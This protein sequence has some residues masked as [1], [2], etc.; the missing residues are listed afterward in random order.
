MDKTF[1]FMVDFTLPFYLDQQFIDLIPQQRAKINKYFLNGQ[2]ANY[3]LSLEKSKL[4]AI[5]NADTRDEVLDIIQDFPL[6]KFMKYRIYP[7]TFNQT[8]NSKVPSFSLN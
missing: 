6:T 1:Q 2:L 3:V 7:L 4:W 8:I 5:L